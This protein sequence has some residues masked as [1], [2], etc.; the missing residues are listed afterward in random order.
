MDYEYEATNPVQVLTSSFPDY[1]DAL[2]NSGKTGNI[3]LQVTVGVDGR[4]TNATIANSQLPEMN[5]ATLA[6]IRKWTFKPF[7][8]AGQPASFTIKLIMKFSLQ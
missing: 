3:T 7:V 1:P 4:V 5:T 2:V 6:A 8:R